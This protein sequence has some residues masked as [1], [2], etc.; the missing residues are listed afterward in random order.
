MEKQ[1]IS[2]KDETVRMF[3]NEILNV[4][5]KVHFLV[6]VILFLPVVIYFIYRAIAIYSMS[7]IS[8]LGFVIGGILTWSL[9]EYLLH[10]FIFHYQP[11]TKIGKRIHFIVHGVHH[12]YPSDSK[13]LVMV[14]SMSIPLA[15]AFYFLFY[16]LMGGAN[17]APFF[18][19]FII[20]YLIYDE[21]HYALHHF[22]FK[23]KF[24]LNIKHHHMIHHYKDSQNGF[25]VSSKI[26]DY[27][28][29]TKFDKK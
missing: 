4:L 28:F 7:F 13:R 18:A 17:T 10:R 19:G 3:D 29:G 27:V 24:W 12:D 15:A 2:N 6:P 9:A 25:G 11:T 16:F 20:G 26:W 8:I 14:P 5:S 22:N 1:Y 21:T 23:S